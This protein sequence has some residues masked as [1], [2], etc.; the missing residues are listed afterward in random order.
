MGRRHAKG[1]QQQHGHAPGAS[2]RCSTRAS[3]ASSTACCAATVF[4]KSWQHNR[5]QQATVN[6]AA[7]G[8]RRASSEQPQC[9]SH[10]LGLVHHLIHHLTQLSGAVN[11]A[12]KT[13]N[14]S[15]GH[16]NAHSHNHTAETHLKPPSPRDRRRPVRLARLPDR[17]MLW[18][19]PIALLPRR[20]TLLRRPREATLRRLGEPMRLGEPPRGT[21]RLRDVGEGSAPPPSPPAPSPSPSLLLSLWK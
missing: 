7:V 20:P 3:C 17:P 19:R 14:T 10:L 21:G 18:R 9:A 15:H 11:K 1:T 12:T 4:L 16:H 6:K 8:C 5:P 2:R 13:V